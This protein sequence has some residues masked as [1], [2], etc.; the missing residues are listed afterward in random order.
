MN[1]RRATVLEM[2]TESYIRSAH[3]VA[4]SVIAKRLSVSSATVR[5]DFCA[6]EEEG[7]LQ[8]PHTSA[9]RIPTR[10]GFETYARKFIPPQQLPAAYR[11]RIAQRLRGAHGDAL[12]QRIADVTAELTGYAVVVSLLADE[13]LHALEV[14]L[15]NLS[16]SRLLAVIVLENGLIR[17]L[18]VELE[19][20]PDEE[21]LREAESRLRQLTLPLA[22]LPQGLADIAKRADAAL[23]QTLVALAGALERA[24]P[25]RLF[26]QGL[27]QVLSEPESSDPAFVR[28]LVGYLENPDLPR[29]DTLTVLFK[30][31]LANV[32]T[33]IPF[34]MADASLI[35]VGPARMRYREALTVAY[36]I[37]QQLAQLN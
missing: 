4:S 26:S 3:P 12:L 34:G 9:G 11:H 29:P 16:S 13:H 7:Y 33:R 14:H 37:S 17:Q 2:V 1:A 27:R 32:A 20:T 30:E 35:I 6:L 18:I 10:L 23:H 22:R 28:Q 36:G 15:S 19:P 21:V 8:Q 5:N 25:P 24:N 31:P